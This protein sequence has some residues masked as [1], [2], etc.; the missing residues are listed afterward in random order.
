MPS[1][2]RGGTSQLMTQPEQRAEKRQAAEE[3][4]ERRKSQRRR[5]GI[6]LLLPHPALSLPL[7]VPTSLEL[8][9]KQYRALG[10]L[11]FF[12]Y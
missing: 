10:T 6:S 5:E 7:P 8:L 1:S 9:Y 12:S 2:H 3:K 11:N 4:E